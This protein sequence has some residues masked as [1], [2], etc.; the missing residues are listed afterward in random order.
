MAKRHAKENI[1]EEI[2]WQL[3]LPFIFFEVFFWLINKSQ[4][5]K[6]LFWGC[7]IFILLFILLWWAN[8]KSKTHRQ[9]LSDIEVL[10][11][12]SSNDFE[13]YIADL[14]S[15]M[16]YKTST[17]G[18]SYDGGIDVVAERNGLKHYIQCK[19]YS[20][21]VGVEKIREFY[22]VLAHN[23]AKGKGIFI[24]TGVFSTEAEYFAND[25]PIELID[26]QGLVK[27]IRQLNPNTRWK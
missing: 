2:M 19:K 18:S 14:Y 3:F 12:L 23:F 5:W 10:K 16:G 13:K 20:G 26:G 7:P 4:F 8:R 24:T 27:L 9:W 22:G 6:L 15:K 17:I 1:L 11:N 21:T 25:K